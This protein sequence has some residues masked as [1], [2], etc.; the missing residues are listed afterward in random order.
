MKIHRP[1]ISIAKIAFWAQSRDDRQFGKA[2]SGGIN[3]GQDLFQLI[4]Y[5][6]HDSA[7]FL[8]R[9]S[10]KVTL[11]CSSL[12]FSSMNLFRIAVFSVDVVCSSTPS[13]SFA[14]TLKLRRPART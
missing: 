11:P 12:S 8:I 4:W 9:A 1:Q 3:N 5:K 6:F 10:A 13:I 2:V 14:V 7:I